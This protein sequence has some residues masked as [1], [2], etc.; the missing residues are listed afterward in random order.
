M[1][2]RRFPVVLTASPCLT[3][4]QLDLNMI[5][6]RTSLEMIGRTGI[7]YS[8]DPM[9]PGQDVTDKYAETLKEL[10]CVRVQ[11]SEVVTLV[12]LTTI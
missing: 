5:L 1:A 9:I 8:F 4:R 7:G 2:H 3:H 11:R 6:N 12:G 10:L